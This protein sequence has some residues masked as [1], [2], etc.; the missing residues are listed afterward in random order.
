MFR[1]LRLHFRHCQV[2][3]RVTTDAL[4][5]ESRIRVRVSMKDLQRGS[6]MCESEP[7]SGHIAQPDIYLA[8][9]DH[10]A[11]RKINLQ[12]LDQIAHFPFTVSISEP[13]TDRA[14]L[15]DFFNENDLWSDEAGAVAIVVPDTGRLLGTA[16]FYRSAPC[17]HGLELGYILH[18][19]ADRGRGLAAP[20]VRLFSDLLFME[21]CD[22]RRQQLI[23][24]VWNTASWRVAER[25]GFTREGIL[26]NSGFDRD[27]PADC[28]V[29]SR[30]RKDFIGQ[31][32]AGVSLGGKPSGK[33]Q[34]IDHA[35]L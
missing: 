4:R 14:R 17:I 23:I 33:E 15:A 10:V 32:S 16:Q 26:R 5:I 21:R 2:K 3:L 20:A 7:M 8:R 35:P 18:D 25:C 34:T 1:V 27:D 28:F 22:F 6:L 12:D 11:I 31:A 29:Y 19:Q 13:L 24:E 9:S 30:T